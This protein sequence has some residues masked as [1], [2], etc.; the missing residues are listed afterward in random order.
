MGGL[1]LTPDEI[2]VTLARNDYGIGQIAVIVKA[3]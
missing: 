3:H 1:S 2:Q